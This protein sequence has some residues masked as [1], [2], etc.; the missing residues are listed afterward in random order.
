MPSKEILSSNAAILTLKRKCPEHKNMNPFHEAKERP[1]HKLLLR[2]QGP[3]GGRNDERSE[4]FQWKVLGSIPRCPL[5]VPVANP[6]L[7]LNDT[8]KH[9]PVAMDM[10]YKLDGDPL[11]MG[12]TDS[13]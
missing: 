8:L 9:L 6:Y 1:E 13:M 11:G 3:P 7:L 10:L 5:S 2:L 12:L 4:W